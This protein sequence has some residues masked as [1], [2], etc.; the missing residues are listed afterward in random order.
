M[1]GASLRASSTRT[2]SRHLQ[3]NIE[4]QPLGQIAI[5]K[6]AFPATC[7]N[8][9]FYYMR[10]LQALAAYELT[11]DS[12]LGR[13]AADPVVTHQTA[14]HMVTCWPDYCFL[15]ASPEALTHRFEGR[16]AGAGLGGLMSYNSLIVKLF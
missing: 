3:N 13:N 8:A 16:W 1:P 10:S 15:Q 2:P 5:R 12:P 11:H 4:N 6:T 7:G 9:V 14:E